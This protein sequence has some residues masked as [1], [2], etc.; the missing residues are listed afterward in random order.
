MNLKTDFKWLKQG[1]VLM[2]V[3]EY[4]MQINL[5]VFTHFREKITVINYFID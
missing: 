2:P 4:T 5:L 1:G 3:I